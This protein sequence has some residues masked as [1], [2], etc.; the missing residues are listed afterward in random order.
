M[1]VS[2]AIPVYEMGGKGTEFLKYCIHS[3]LG[4]TYPIYEIVI[5]DHSKNDDIFNLCNPWPPN[6]KYIRN[7]KNYGVFASN[8]NNCFNYCTG[9]IIKI[10]HQD[11]YFYSP[12]SLSEIVDS[13]DLEKGWLVSSYY[14]SRDGKK[15]FRLH[16]PTIS[17]CPL[18]DNKIGAPTCLTIKNE[19]VLYFDDKLKWYVDSD[20]YT[21]LLAKY[22]APVIL[23]KPTV[24]QRLWEGQVTNTIIHKDMITKE[25]LYLYKKH[26]VK[27]DNLTEI[28]REFGQT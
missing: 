17:Q 27:L 4:Q 23:E 18:F 13:F 21:G 19:D 20:Y 24:V 12:D 8:M 1:R 22:G 9:D 11:D 5:S 28:I 2:V 16:T 25:I 26:D 6:V 10:M 7:K 15:F 3:I 14:H